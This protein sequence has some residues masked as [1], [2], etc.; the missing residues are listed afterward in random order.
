MFRTAVLRKLFDIRFSYK[1]CNFSQV[2][3]LVKMASK[4]VTRSTD[5]E[6]LY[7]ATFICQYGLFSCMAL[8]SFRLFYKN[9]G[10]SQEFFGQ[11]DY[12]PP[13]QKIAR[14]PM[15]G[16]LTLVNKKPFPVLFEFVFWLGFF[17]SPMSSVSFYASFNLLHVQ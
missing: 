17:L 6:K 13:W 1:Q 4:T 9:L 14:T 12:R 5:S 15:S 3:L 2:C 7:R 11:M 8:V 10:N 16:A